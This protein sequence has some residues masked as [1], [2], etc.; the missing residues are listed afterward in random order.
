MC[1]EETWRIYNTNVWTY[2]A[3]QCSLNSARFR[4]VQLRSLTFYGNWT[5]KLLELLPIGRELTCSHSKH[6]VVTIMPVALCC[7]LEILLTS[8]RLDWMVRG[9]IFVGN[10]GCEG[11][12]LF[13]SCVILCLNQK[14]PLGFHYGVA[15]MDLFFWPKFS[16]C[17]AAEKQ[18]WA[19]AP[20]TPPV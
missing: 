14:F 4:I 2:F 13:Q 17:E 19:P 16:A 6:S 11:H 5:K 10:H 20:P 1:F 12:I 15:P 18:C 7:Q 3:G 8:E 9:D